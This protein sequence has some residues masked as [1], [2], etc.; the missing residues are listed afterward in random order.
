M[1]IKLVIFDLDGTVVDNNY[2]WAAIRQELG[3][4]SGSIL[5]C[6]DN[7]PEP[8]RS[9]KYA[10]LEIHERRQTEEARLKPGARE[11]LGW[12]AS[13]QIMTALV[14][15]NS[16]QNASFLL[17]RFGLKFNLI[18]TRESGLYKPSGAPLIRVRE[19]LGVD[20][21]EAVVVGD[22]SYDLLAAREAGIARIFILKSSM[23]P[24]NLNGA[25]VVSS[26]EE[27]RTHLEET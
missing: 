26:F 10:L 19:Q 17:N 12:L 23:T 5:A 14:T 27:I 3:I 8:E 2:D 16:Q 1:K 7:L 11:F 25:T 9:Q 18:L 24:V 13:R 6:L 21:E 4:K 20:A 15:N 22:T